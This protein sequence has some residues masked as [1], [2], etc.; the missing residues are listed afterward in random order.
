VIAVIIVLNGVLGYVQEA[1]A[2]EAVEA[3]QRMTVASAIVS[4]DGRE[5]R[6]A[7]T[8][9]VPGDVLILG[10]G[11]AVSADGRLVQSASLQAAETSLTGESETVLKDPETIEGE[12]ALGDRLNMV[13]SGTRRSSRPPRAA[14][15]RVRRVGGVVL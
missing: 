8:E 5:Q 1:R 3:L 12:V 6:I 11:D 4:R 13:F 2:E 9:V 14:V 15:G 10:E 7:S